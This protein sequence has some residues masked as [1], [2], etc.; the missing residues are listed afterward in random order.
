MIKN[1]IPL[2]CFTYFLVL[3]AFAPFSSL[4]AQEIVL[5][6]EDTYK[7][8]NAVF[9]RKDT[10]M[11]ISYYIQAGKKLKN[12][13]H[14]YNVELYYSKDGGQTFRGPMKAVKGDVG[15]GVKAT[16]EKNLKIITWK[17]LEDDDDF[18]GQ[19]I[20]LEVRPT[21]YIPANAKHNKG[22]QFGALNIIMPGLGDY[23][24]RP[25]SGRALLPIFL[26][27][28]IGG[29]VYANKMAKDSYN[30]YLTATDISPMNTAYD[31]AKIYDMV[32]KGMVYTAIGIWGIDVIT[33][34]IKGFRN[35]GFRAKYEN[36]TLKKSTTYAPKLEFFGGYAGTAGQLGV[37][38]KF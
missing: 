25:G 14:L 33:A 7:Y 27:A 30:K 15:M 18:D 28:L 35:Q 2:G 21:M 23:F 11:E 29:G 32:S 19:N 20:V 17:P 26:G 36:Q 6:D 38:L 31:E 13:A 37:R 8:H 34:V 1:I 3:L 5:P 24:V 9:V 12:F 16:L 22:P 4:L 10:T